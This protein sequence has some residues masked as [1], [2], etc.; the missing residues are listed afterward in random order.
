MKQAECGTLDRCLAL[1]IY[2]RES[3]PC[4][5]LLRGKRRAENC[6]LD[7]E[8]ERTGADLV[9]RLGRGSVCGRTNDID[10]NLKVM[11]TE[12]RSDVVSTI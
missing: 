7:L 2:R 10:R 11:R 4:L 6:P 12:W 9:E 3:Q 5:M 8:R 1:N